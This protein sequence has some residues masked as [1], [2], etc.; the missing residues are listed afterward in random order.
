MDHLFSNWSTVKFILQLLNNHNCNFNYD[1]PLKIINK[2]ENVK[3]KYISF[4]NGW[5]GRLQDKN[6]LYSIH[7]TVLGSNGPGVD[8]LDVFIWV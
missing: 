6:R 5:A 4:R 7:P 2:Y 3:Y 8:R 1:I